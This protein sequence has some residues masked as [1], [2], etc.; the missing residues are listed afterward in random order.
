MNEVVGR[1]DLLL[2]TLD[3]LRYD[4]ARRSSRPG[5]AEPRRGAARRRWEERHSPGS[6]TYAAH[7]AF[8]AGFL[9]TP[10]APGPHPRLFAARFAGSE[11][12]A[13]RHLRLRRARPRHRPRRARLP[14][15]LRR[16]GRLLQ[17]ADAAGQR[18]AG[19]VRRE[20]L[21]AGVR[22]RRARPRSRPRWTRAPSV[23]AGRPPDSA[24]FLFLNVSAL[25]QPNWFYLPGA[26]RE[27]ATAGQPRR[28]AGY[29]DRH[30]AP[31]FDAM[32]AA[33][34]LLRDRLLRPRHRLRRGR[35][36]RPPARPRGRVDRAVRRVRPGAD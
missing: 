13:R 11:T 16:R 19:A 22:R 1:D 23:I 18:A 7:H 25:H 21:G 14:H 35:L 8:F 28:R 12:T 2:V 4:V 10:A 32:R 17:Q 20:P 9:P 33:R 36:H 3:T 31:L 6:F 5:T 30:L 26:A 29:V 15:G 34:P 27:P 24:L